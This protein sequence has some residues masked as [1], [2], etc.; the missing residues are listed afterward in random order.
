MQSRSLWSPDDQQCPFNMS[1][2]AESGRSDRRNSM[3][4]TGS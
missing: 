1:A 3:K 2:F 4:L